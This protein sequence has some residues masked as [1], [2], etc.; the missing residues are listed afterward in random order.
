MKWDQS[1]DY[2]SEHCK[3]NATCNEN[4]EFYIKTFNSSLPMWFR[5]ANC[6]KS[7]YSFDKYRASPWLAFIGSVED[8]ADVFKV[9][10]E[11][12][13]SNV[14]SLQ[15]LND[16]LQPGHENTWLRHAI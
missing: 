10:S 13:T 8:L 1:I 15:S 6:S 16:I 3:E 4:H 12:V 2:V 5:I 7:K 11:V 9:F 14:I